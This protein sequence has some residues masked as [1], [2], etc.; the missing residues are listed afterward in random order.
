MKNNLNHYFHENWDFMLF[1]FK[2]NFA[3]FLIY[4]IKDALYLIFSIDEGKMIRSYPPY[5]SDT[6]RILFLFIYVL[7][8]VMRFIYAFM[9]T[10]GINFK[11]WIWSIYIG[12]QITCYFNQSSKFL[13]KNKLYKEDPSSS[14]FIT[15]KE[16]MIIFILNLICSFLVNY[17]IFFLIFFLKQLIGCIHEKYLLKSDFTF[18]F[19]NIILFMK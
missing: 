3:Y 12:R 13:F 17:M 1:L 11:Y 9:N 5:Y 16:I 8:N 10:K 15:I 14:N 2:V 18:I 7:A 4:I 19:I 6:E